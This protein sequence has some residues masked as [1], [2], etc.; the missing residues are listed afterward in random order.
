MFP[1]RDFYAFFNRPR[2]LHDHPVYSIQAKRHFSSPPLLTTIAATMQSYRVF[3]GFPPQS[4]TAPNDINVNCPLPATAIPDTIFISI[5]IKK[6]CYAKHGLVGKPQQPLTEVGVS[7]LDVSEVVGE[8]PGDRGVGLRPFIHDRHYIVE[9]ELRKGHGD[10]GVCNAGHHQGDLLD[11]LFTK[12]E[13]VTLAT[14]Q[15]VVLEL[16]HD[17][18]GIGPASQNSM[19]TQSSPTSA[20]SNSSSASNVLPQADASHGLDTSGGSE[21]LNSSTNLAT[22]LPHT[23][24]A[25]KVRADK[26]PIKSVPSRYETANPFTALSG[27]GESSEDSEQQ[28]RKP[29]KKQLKKAMKEQRKQQLTVAQQPSDALASAS[30]PPS[31]AWDNTPVCDDARVWYDKPVKERPVKA[32]R[33]PDL[34]QAG[35]NLFFIFH[36]PRGDITDLLRQ[37]IDL[38]SHHFPGRRILDT[39]ETSLNAALQGPGSR[40]RVRP[41]LITVLNRAGVAYESL[42]NGSNDARDTLEAFLAMAL[43]TNGQHDAFLGGALE[44]LAPSWS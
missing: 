37:G 31:A 27:I 14:V 36:D 38:S 19:P 20:P 41:K 21:G 13:P 24:D 15:G 6:F 33:D 26:N 10:N 4:H 43:T 34:I 3:F 17:I 23:R 12:P 7:W 39:Q 40:H 22:T 35:R 32:K 11:S 2:S 9:D 8:I 44:S 29:S 30:I 5:D 25:V 18:T 28:P 42:H 1:T 16:L